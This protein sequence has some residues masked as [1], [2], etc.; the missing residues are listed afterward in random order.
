MGS[1]GQPDSIAAF[2]GFHNVAS[3]QVDIDHRTGC[4]KSLDDC[5]LEGGHV[6]R[7]FQPFLFACAA[8]RGL[9]GV[10]RRPQKGRMMV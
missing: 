2:L 10:N 1:V 3:D 5:R 6:F 4:A 9:P 7:H 8:G